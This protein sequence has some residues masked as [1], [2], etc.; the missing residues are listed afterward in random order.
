VPGANQLGERLIGDAVA[1]ASVWTDRL[2]A[3]GGSGLSHRQTDEL[4]PACQAY[5]GA[6]GRY[7][8]THDERVLR[9]VAAGEAIK[10]LQVG[11][12]LDDLVGAYRGLQDL[13]WE[14]VGREEIGG[15]PL[16]A[17]LWELSGAIALS[18]EETVK[19]YQK[20]L[21]RQIAAH[22]GT[23]EDL[24]R[25]LHQSTSIDD[26]TG[27]FSARVFH[28]YLPREIQ[29]AQ[30]YQRPLSV[31][32]FDVDD[33]SRLVDLC[34]TSE[35]DRALQELAQVIPSQVREV[36]IMCRLAVDEFAVILPETS[37]LHAV[38]VAE[39]IRSATEEHPTFAH[40]VRA[41]GPIRVSAGVA[42][43]PD[44]APEAQA[45]VTRAREACQRAKRLGKN[46]VAVFSETRV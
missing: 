3:A 18:I 44:D 20:Q 34:G 43:F 9:E 41:S 6:L 45:L 17:G 42:G 12:P 32:V 22:Q 30:R 35:G 27:L 7:L 46:H 39:R 21:A 36:D 14:R 1:I 31:V 24:A 2:A 23:V 33:F 13:L 15:G 10:R 4:L 40:G 38:A 26:L 11:F 25:Q 37:V 5:V 16:E 29:R 28:E 19:A 8:L